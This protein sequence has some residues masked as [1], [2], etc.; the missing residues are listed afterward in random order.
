MPEI[1][2]VAA[3]AEA[4]GAAGDR[5]IGDGLELPWHIPAD[6]ERFKAMTL[7]HPLVMGRRTFE[8]LL[9]QFGGPLPGRETVVLTRHP[10]SVRPSRHPRPLVR[11]R[12][13]PP[14]RS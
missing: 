3:V 13:P 12:R 5:L 7:G 2:V 9:H 14:A 11:R 6:L 10:A 1:V 8:S 4:P